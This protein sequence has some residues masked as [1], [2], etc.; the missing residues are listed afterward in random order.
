V[1]AHAHPINGTCDRRNETAAP[2]T[3]A[4]G[5]AVDVHTAR[6]VAPSS[7]LCEGVAGNGDRAQAV[8]ERPIPQLA[9]DIQTCASGAHMHVGITEETQGAH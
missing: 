7:E 2:L 5:T 6:M 4:H 3:P 1:P 8:S 9:E